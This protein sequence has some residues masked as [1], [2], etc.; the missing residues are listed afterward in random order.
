MD[1]AQWLPFERNRYYWGKM[2][3][4]EDFLAEQSYMNRKRQFLNHM[5]LGRGVLCGMGVS[6]LDDLSVLVE[7][8]AAIDAYGREIVI[9]ESVVQKL[10]G[11]QGYKELTGEEASLCVRYKEEDIKQ[12]YVVDRREGEPEYECNRIVEGY[13]FCIVDRAGLTGQLQLDEEFFVEG[14]LLD[15]EDWKVILRAPA[16]VTK[17]KLFRIMAEVRK[18]TD[19]EEPINFS[20]T[21]QMPLFLNEDGL[22]E[23]RIE[24][25]GLKLAKGQT[26][27]QDYWV[28]AK[29]TDLE[30]TSLVTK[31]D[32]AGELGKDFS[33]KIMLTDTKPEEVIQKTL[34][35]LNLELQGFGEGTDLVRLADLRLLKTPQ[36]Y[37][38]EKVYD[39][40]ARTFIPLPVQEQ[41]KAYYRSYFSEAVS[42]YREMEG[43]PRK[44]QEEEAQAEEKRG[45]ENS[46]VRQMQT[47]S[48]ILEI[49]MDAYMKK[50]RVCF[51]EEIVHGLGSGNVCVTV[52]AKTEDGSVIIGD[53]SC[54][55]KEDPE[56]TW[57]LAAVKI[58]PERGSFQAAVR[59][60]GELKAVVLTMQWYAFK[61]QDTG[62][63]ERAERLERDA[64]KGSI[65]PDTGS[66]Y[67]EPKESC[68][69]G[70]RFHNMKP[71]RLKY[72]VMEADGGTIEDDGTYTAPG[73]SG[74]YEIG[75]SCED[76]PKICTYAYAVVQRKGKKES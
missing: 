70:V 7:S 60:K 53:T 55:A 30:E 59:L 25:R 61:I 48:G 52:A 28:L 73:K 31:A 39:A 4:P 35:K 29:D 72:R 46:A 58:F 36:G 76:Y 40:D 20:G 45:E 14:E 43:R 75:I 15:T 56:I 69:I 54:F 5:V 34:G 47:A 17:N 65:V 38:I 57:L 24:Q 67:L 16:A 27:R 22:Q 62:A 64:E 71:C 51:S 37:V 6:N 3:S 33:L 12:V 11:I 18:K 10:S 26:A 21:V 8:G 49:P 68:Y 13:E 23:L 9:E 63:G 44:L 1:R 66:V 50:G 74:V 41:K 19:N 32:G 2:L 42:G